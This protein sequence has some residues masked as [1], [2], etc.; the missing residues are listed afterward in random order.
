MLNAKE[1][2]EEIKKN[3][4]KL[5]IGTVIE[6]T[7][8]NYKKIALISGLIY[9]ILGIISVVVILAIIGT[10]VGFKDF[11][12]AMTGFKPENISTT[13][14][15]Y[16]LIG[17][18]LITIIVSPISAGMINICRMVDNNEEISIGNAFDYYKNGYLKNIFVS[19]FIVSLL[20]IGINFI[21]EFFDFKIIGVFI[22]LIISFFTFLTLP[23]VIFGNLDPIKAI[24]SSIIV[25]SKNIGI[26]I[27]ILILGFIASIIGVF[28]CCVGMLFTMPF[29]NSTYYIIYK[30]AVGVDNTTEI[31][32]IG[33][34]IE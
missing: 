14:L 19:I 21:F 2:I 24:S 25:V 34:N 17:T 3:G 31:D 5:D 20:T 16:Q 9:L 33:T 4:Y 1:R 18:I 11:S 29:I 15:I 8:E 23:L 27:L 30:N 7:F 10:A 32:E 26:L 28:A 6:Q 22:S 13:M 12:E